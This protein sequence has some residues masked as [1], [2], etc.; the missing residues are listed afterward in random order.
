MT[1][2]KLPSLT[3]LAQITA[4]QN[5]YAIGMGTV[6]RVSSNASRDVTGI[7]GGYDGRVASFINVGSNA[8]NFLDENAGSTAANRIIAA[9]A[10]SHPLAANDS[11]TMIYDGT[12]A[13]WRILGFHE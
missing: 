13:R 1:M 6:F 4:T 10:T 8:I 7:A 3:T 12:S 5:D 2:T 9:H 11:V